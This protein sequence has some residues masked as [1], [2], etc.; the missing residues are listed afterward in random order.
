M[1]ML[2][3]TVSVPLVGVRLSRWTVPDRDSTGG[4]W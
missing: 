1:A 4:P 3:A 2:V